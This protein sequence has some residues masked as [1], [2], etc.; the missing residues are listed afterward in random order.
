MD[1]PRNKIADF[2]NTNQHAGVKYQAVN[3]LTVVTKL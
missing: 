1:D 3:V 2:F